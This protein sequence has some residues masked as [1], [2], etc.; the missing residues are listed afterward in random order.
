MSFMEELNILGVNTDEGLDRV[1]GDS[2][3]YEMML[4]MFVDSVGSASISMEEF[5][6]GD[7]DGLIQK[8]HTL[9]GT[10]GN[11]ALTPLFNS[12]TKMLGQLRGGQ[13]DSA[14]AE[15]ERMLPIQTKIIDCINQHQNG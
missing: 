8:V 11:L 6:G 7:L 13:K 14:R 3:L 10:A 15:Y 2:G 5:S 12:Y 9:K 1:M 4:G